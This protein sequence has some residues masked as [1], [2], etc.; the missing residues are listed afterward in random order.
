MLPPCQGQAAAA[1]AAAVAG[2]AAVAFAP[3]VVQGLGKLCAA[4][5][6]AGQQQLQGGLMGQ[7][8]L[9]LATMLGLLVAPQNCRLAALQVSHV[10]HLIGL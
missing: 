9:V 6:V 7:L 5:L 2:M 10:I 8:P 4:A 3:A 1:A